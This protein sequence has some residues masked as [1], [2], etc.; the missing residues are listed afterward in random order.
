MVANQSDELS[1]RVALVTG[2]SGDIGS[3]IVR[4]LARRGAHVAIHY[5]QNKGQAQRLSEELNDLGVKSLVTGGDLAQQDTLRR[6][7]AESQALGPIDILINNAGT[8]I[9]RV[10]WLEIDEA[11][12]DEVFNLNF[13]AAFYLAQQVVPAMVERGK[14]VIINILTTAVHMGGT[15]TVLA[16]GAAKGALFT[17]TKGLA[18]P[19]APQ[20]VRVLAISPGTVDT[21][22]QRK[23]TPPEIMEQLLSTNP[24][25]R[26]GKPEEIGEIVAFMATDHASFVVGETIEIN[27]GVYMR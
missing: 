17:L 2:G 14:G 10:P 8:P 15:D 21:N 3:A 11:F 5:H 12:L 9:R 27:G 7:V 24:L 6:I 23:L 1:G 20:G 19:L 16:Y 4:A 26:A 18:R 22:I 25:G 13:R